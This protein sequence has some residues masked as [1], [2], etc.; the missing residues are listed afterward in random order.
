MKILIVGGGTFGVTLLKL[1]LD[2]GF[3]VSLIEKNEEIAKTIKEEYGIE[4]ISG[5]AMDTLILEEAGIKEADA[6]VCATS[7]E[8]VNTFVALLAKEYGVKK[9]FIRV[10]E[11]RIVPFLIKMGMTNFF[12]FSPEETMAHYLLEMLRDIEL[13][14][15]IK[16]D[17]SKK[18]VGIKAS[19]LLNIIGKGIEKISGRGYRALFLVK[20]NGEVAFEKSIVEEDDT[21]FL[22]STLDTK[23]LLD[24]LR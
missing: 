3:K 4:V 21:I 5:D 14:K 19:K 23:T 13:L 9:I 18:I 2:N 7:E 12:S 20:K 15:L 24:K 1:L 17:E 10:R 22:F 16:I 11:K 6:V 8:S